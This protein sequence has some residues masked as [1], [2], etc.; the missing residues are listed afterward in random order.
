MPQAKL[1]EET[2]FTP[3]VRTHQDCEYPVETKRTILE[4][5]SHPRRTAMAD[6]QQ[7]AKKIEPDPELLKLLASS[8]PAT[9]EELRAQRISFAFGNAPVDSDKLITKESVRLASEN[10]RLLR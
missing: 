9:E 2:A 3:F 6:R 5:N 10:I 4:L 8:S 7:F 1:V